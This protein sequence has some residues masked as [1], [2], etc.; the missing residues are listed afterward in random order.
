MKIS[1]LVALS[2]LVSASSAV[3]ISC[4]H[5]SSSTQE[6]TVAN[7]NESEADRLS[8]AMTSWQRKQ[9]LSERTAGRAP[10]I[11]EAQ[12]RKI[13]RYVESLQLPA[14]ESELVRDRLFDS[15]TQFIF[16]D[17]LNDWQCL[18]ADPRVTPLAP[19]RRATQSELGKPARVRAPLR[20]NHY[21]TYQWYRNRKN[22]ELRAEIPERPQLAGELAALLEQKWSRVS[23]AI[24]GIDGIGEADR[25]GS[26]N[27]S[28]LSVFRGIRGQADARA[29]VDVES[30]IN[31]QSPDREMKYQY[32]PTADLCE[33]LNRS[34]P[35]ER[36]R[37]RLEWPAA[38][39][40]H[41]KFFVF[42]KGRNQSVWTGT[43]NISKNCIGD[44]SFAN[45]SIYIRNREVAQSF[46]KEFEE[47]F[48]IDPA[49]SAPFPVGR[50]HQNKRPDTPR[51]FTFNDGTELRVHFSPTDDGEHRVIIPLLRSAE[52]GDEIRVSMFGSGGSE[53]VRAL[54]YA[55]SKGADVKVLVDR[56][57]SFQISNSWINRKA[58]VRLQDENPY[59]RRGERS[60]DLKVRHTDWLGGSMNHHK[61][62]TLTRRHADGRVSHTLIV[63]SQNWSVAGNDENDENMVTIRRIGRVLPAAQDF[64]RHF[65]SLLWPTGKPVSAE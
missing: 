35:N 52:A 33:A 6:R 38:K 34:E 23:M 54:Q 20:M 5:F 27:N 21:F 45:M 46:L 7:T 55:Q 61:T 48:V 1:S 57:T 41:N 9:R 16:C 8:A 44:E 31:S 40:M 26:A 53:Y 4:S 28:M 43:A 13:L 29:V 15:V 49:V 60:G 42:E 37:V 10:E 59:I 19:Y 11:T 58:A 25:Q 3:L 14:E 22:Q 24:Y 18:E 36:A 51:Y 32:P 30:Y 39:I 63:G 47:M 12:M 2:L 64:N 65:D 50:F 62:A 56:D 17:D